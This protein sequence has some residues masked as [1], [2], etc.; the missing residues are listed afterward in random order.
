[1]TGA[2]S[3]RGF[4]G[5]TR[6]PGLQL[7]PSAILYEDNHLI[8][9][10]KKAGEIVQGDITGDLPLNE[11]LKQYVKTKYNKPGEV[12]LGVPHRIDR[13]TS[14]IVMFCRNS[15]SLERINQ[16]FKD[17]TIKKTYWA[18]VKNQPPEEADTLIHWVKKKE[19]QNKTY[20]Y[21]KEVDGSLYAELDYKIISESDYYYLLE[22]NLKTGRHH[23]IRSQLAKI[24]CPIK[25]DVKYGF[26]RPNQ[27]GSIHLHARKISF[28]HPMKKELIELTAPVP[29]EPLWKYFEKKLMEENGEQPNDHFKSSL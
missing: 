8:V 22:I 29:D 5:A 16:M 28:I 4:T 12:Y 17:K 11:M 26:D 19:Q 27:D 24:G 14:G 2:P 13:P 23:Q 25:G 3:D 20:S 9:I 1:M 15:R 7:D 18:V 21:D 10:N 6:N